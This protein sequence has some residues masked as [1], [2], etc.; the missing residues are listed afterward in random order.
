MRNARENGYEFITVNFKMW[1][2]DEEEP[3]NAF[4]PGKND[5]WI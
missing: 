5:I 1:K 2:R 3:L 4:K